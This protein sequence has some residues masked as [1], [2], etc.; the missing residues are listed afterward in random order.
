[1][2]GHHCLYYDTLNDLCGVVASFLRDGIRK[3]MLCLWIIPEGLE[4]ETAKETLR[5]MLKDLDRHVETGQLEIREFR[6]WYIP[7][8]KF[9]PEETLLA[10]AQ[11]ESQALERGFSGLC[12]IGD[13]SRLLEEDR[14]KLIAYENSVGKVIAQSKISAL[15]TYSIEK[16]RP[17]ER[18]I[19]SKRHSVILSNLQGMLTISN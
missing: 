17:E 5:G 3:R 6:G 16:F 15:C 11:K 12:A 1:M 8:G 7:S 13:G 19:I 9:D 14:E 4:V 10:W 18:E 2:G